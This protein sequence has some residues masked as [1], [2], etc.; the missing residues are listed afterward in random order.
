MEGDVEGDGVAR[1]LRARDASAD[2][3]GIELVEASAEHAVVRM[4]ARP[5]MCNGYDLVHGG[6]TFLL[7]DTAMAFASCAGNETALAT[8]AEVDWVAPARAGQVLTAT[9]RLRWSGGRTSLWDVTV[10]ADG[11]VVAIMRGRTRTVGGAIVGS[12]KP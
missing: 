3:L 8:S 12:P 9:A 6:I 7:A 10:D 5:D 11:D 1:R 4:A 2:A